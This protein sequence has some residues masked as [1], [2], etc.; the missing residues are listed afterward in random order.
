[1]LCLFLC[2]LSNSRGSL[3]AG[4]F[5]L[6]PHHMLVVLTTSL[7]RMKYNLSLIDAAGLYMNQWVETC[8]LLQGKK[9]ILVSVYGNISCFFSQQVQ[10]LPSFGIGHSLGSLI[11]LLIGN[12]CE[13]IKLIQLISFFLYILSWFTC[14]SGSRYAVQRNGNIFMAFNNKVNRFIYIPRIAFPLMKALWSIT[15]ITYLVSTKVILSL[16]GRYCESCYEI[17]EPVKL[18]SLWNL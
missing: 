15:H 8:S 10:D 17:T 12:F 13:S 11:H 5:W 6:L 7:L 9:D 2:M 1:M 18:I 3:L 16:V 14:N 4:M